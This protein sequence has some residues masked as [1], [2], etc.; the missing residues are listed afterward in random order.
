MMRWIYNQI[1]SFYHIILIVI[2]FVKDQ[3]M[4]GNSIMILL[5]MAG[6]SSFI[7][8]EVDKKH[9]R[10]IDK[11][12]ENK[13]TIQDGS[14]AQR[15]MIVTLKSMQKSVEEVRESVKKTEERVWQLSQK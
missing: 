10:A 11:I 1:M 15:E 12:E 3:K 6:A 4:V 9:Q 5:I 14:L 7:L 2:Q 8:A 13:E